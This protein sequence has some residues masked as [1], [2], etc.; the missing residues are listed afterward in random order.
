MPPPLL[1][2][3]GNAELLDLPA[4][5]IIPD[6]TP[7]ALWESNGREGPQGGLVA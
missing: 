4:I 7:G 6:A 2:V 5:G 1:Y 3:K